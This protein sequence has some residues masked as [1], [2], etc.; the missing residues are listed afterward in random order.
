M[1]FG[2]VVINAVIGFV[3]EGKAER[4]L[5]AIQGMIDPNA[6]VLR[7]G[8]RA[9]IPAASIVPGDIVLLEA[10]DRVAADLRLT[11]AR[12][13]R[14]DEAVLTGESFPSTRARR[15]VSPD[16]LT[17]RPTAIAYSGTLVTSGM[18]AGVAVATATGT[19]RGRISTMR[20]RRAPDH[21]LVRQMNQFARQVTWT[22]LVACAWCSPMRCWRRSY[23]TDEAFMAVVGI[24]V[25][26]IPEGLPAVLTITLAVGVRRMARRN[27]IIRQLPAVETW[28]PCP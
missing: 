26:A 28:V 15:R 14:I 27:A 6:T 1:I 18:G 11:K 16:A 12:N 2:V 17:R 23:P 19:E 20:Q 24:A 4:A 13:L 8:R 3:Q 10:G 22:V 7:D 25:A 21:A 9:S 5:D